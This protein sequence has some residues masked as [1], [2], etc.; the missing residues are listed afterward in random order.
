MK[1]YPCDIVTSPIWTE[2][3]ST[4]GIKFI[5]SYRNIYLKELQWNGEEIH[6]QK[7]IRLGIMEKQNS[8]G[9]KLEYHSS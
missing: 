1:R 3:L 2:F 8:E 4:K 9:K 5:I 7:Y 6:N